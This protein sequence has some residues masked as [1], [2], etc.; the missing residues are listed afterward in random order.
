MIADWS[1]WLTPQP[2]FNEVTSP[3]K[4]TGWQI[5]AGPFGLLYFIPWIPVVRLI[6]RR[7]PVGAIVTTG[8]LWT[9]LTISPFS[10]LYFLTY[11]GIGATW[12]V[13]LGKAR[14]RGTLGERGMIALTWI[15]LH[16]WALP[17][18]LHADIFAYGWEWTPGGNLAVLHALGIAYFLFRFVGW[19]VDWAKN[20]HL[21]LRP[22]ETIAWI[23]YPPVMR[24][25]P[26]MPREVFL[27]RFE[28]WRPAAP[29]PWREIGKHVGWFL[30]GGL[31]L[32]GVQMNT[33]VPPE[34][35]RDFFRS[36]SDYSTNALL[37]IFYF[38]PIRIY[39]ILWLYN[40]LAAIVSFSVGI[41]ADN[42]FDMLPRATSVRDFWRRW[43]ITVGAWLRKYIY[44]PLGGNRGFVE[45]HYIAVFGYCGIWH[46]ASWSFLAWGLSQGIALAVQRWW[47]L[48]RIRLG[49]GTEWKHP[50]W[51]AFCWL[52]TMHYQLATILMFTDFDLL[53]TRFFPEL[54]SRF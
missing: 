11:V 43:H 20:P 17:A 46:G 15:G 47:D 35:A 29:L 2:L 21:S 31:L 12:V 30:A 3:T 54:L 7:F 14:K 53:G 34:G 33:P 49:W 4:L 9:L 52:L 36:P 27:E 23:M 13:L 50:L 45:W 44:I 32:A 25:G 37:R 41:R 6:A 18:W 19:G 8:V 40:E 1:A 10:T 42:N 22:A 38:V 26:V 39:L 16:L 48:L 5:A 24:L 28:N 51:V